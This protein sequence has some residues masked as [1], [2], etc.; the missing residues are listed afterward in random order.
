MIHPN[1]KVIRSKSTAS[2]VWLFQIA[3]SKAQ[4]LDWRWLWFSAPT[5]RIVHPFKLEKKLMFAFQAP[6]PHPDPRDVGAPWET[7][8]HWPGMKHI[9]QHNINFQDIWCTGNIFLRPSFCKTFSHYFLNSEHIIWIQSTLFEFRAQL[10]W[11]GLTFALAAGTPIDTGSTFNNNIC[12]PLQTVWQIK[13]QILAPCIL[14]MNG[15]IRTPMMQADNNNDAGCVTPALPP[16]LPPSLTGRCQDQGFLI[17]FS[18]SLSSAWH[19]ISLFR[20]S[21]LSQCWQ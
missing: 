15:M 20:F 19:R 21:V 7:G 18:S 3:K 17:R 16:P 14:I 9:F 13:L 10:L 4:R 8:H 2:L 1:I 5:L 11:A 6:R 12:L